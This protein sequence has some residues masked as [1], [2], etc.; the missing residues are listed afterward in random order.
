MLHFLELKIY[1]ILYLFNN[2]TAIN[3]IVEKIKGLE[4][5]TDYFLRLIAELFYTLMM[6]RLFAQF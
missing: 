3:Y 1:F 6:E 4:I 2:V 5:S